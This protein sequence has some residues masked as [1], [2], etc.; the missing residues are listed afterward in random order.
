[1]E[2]D[3]NTI[4]LFHAL[5][6]I[7]NIKRFYISKMFHRNVICVVYVMWYDN[8]KLLYFLKIKF[9]FFL[10]FILCSNMNIFFK[11]TSNKILILCL[12]M[13]KS[14]LFLLNITFLKPGFL[15]ENYVTK[16]LQAILIW[17]QFFHDLMISITDFLYWTFFFLIHGHINIIFLLSADIAFSLRSHRYN[18]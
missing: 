4:V 17:L 12:I 14:V 15:T 2:I 3:S 1:M 8:W 11:I 5:Q 18:L 7:E 13:T 10:I 9:L 16:P 6:N